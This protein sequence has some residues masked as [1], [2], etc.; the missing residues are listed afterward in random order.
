MAQ[1][2]QLAY[3]SS[4]QFVKQVQ[5]LKNVKDICDA[6]CG[7][8]LQDVMNSN[9]SPVIPT[10]TS[11][12]SNP[13]FAITTSSN[14]SDTSIYNPYH[15]FDDNVEKIWCSGSGLY[16][17]GV[18]AGSSQTTVEGVGSVSGEWLQMEFTTPV[19]NVSKVSIS[20]SQIVSI[21][22]IKSG[23]IV[24]DDGNGVW[25]FFA[26]IGHHTEVKKYE[27]SVDTPVTMKR[28]RTIITEETNQTACLSN[29]QIYSQG[30]RYLK[31][32]FP[33]GSPTHSSTVAGHATVAGA[34]VTVL[35]AMLNTH[36]ENGLKKVWSP[37]VVHS[38]TGS[39]LDSYAGADK[40]QMTIVG[41]LNKLASNVSLGRDWSSVHFRVDGDVGMVLG[42]QYSITYLVDKCREYSE[43][44]NGIFEGFTLE[45]FSGETVKIT[46]DGVEAV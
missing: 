39:S 24:Y 1:R 2:I 14:H 27:Y 3:E 40:S 43:S 33:E 7:D 38:L 31:L 22:P 12:T 13:G 9:A 18:Y 44:Y 35:K 21:Q 8:L 45:K 19:Q 23:T 16:P 4:E 5:G 17:G 46:K 42:E 32:L 11:N 41:E 34:C 20:N 10:L 30:E 36:D 29:I 37:D 26:E 6:K 25:R 28:F 15:A